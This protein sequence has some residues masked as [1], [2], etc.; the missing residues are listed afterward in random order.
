MRLTTLPLLPLL[1]VLLTS[2]V[3]TSNAT[4][5]ASETAS[6]FAPAAQA[7]AMPAAWHLDTAEHPLVAG[8]P[9]LE[10]AW[11]VSR[12]P[13]GEFDR[14]GL[15]RYRTSGSGSSSVATL[16][17]LP[18]TNMNGIA[19]VKDEAHNLWL[20]LAARGVEVFTIDY[21]THA[22]PIHATAEQ[23]AVLRAW[24]IETF[25]GDIA[26]AAVQVRHET[27][28]DRLYVAGFSRGVSL[29]Y[30]Y[31]CTEPDR[32]AGL[33]HLDGAFKSHAPTSQFDYAAAL[34]KLETG[35]AWASDVAA[36]LGWDRRHQL[37]ATV[38]ANPGAPAT[39]A[40]FPTLGDQLASL[41]QFAWRPGGLANPLGGL[42]KPQTLAT[43]LDGYDRYYPAV[44]DIDGRSIA[45]RPDD[46]RTPVDDAWGKLKTPILHFAST[47][48]GGEFLL[49]GIYTVDKS[50]SS[51]VTLNVLERYGH[52][53]LVVGEQAAR[54]VFQPT[55]D[56][57]KAHAAAR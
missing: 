23:L 24:G 56:W 54:D 10:T 48:M 13:G 5:H 31:T 35:H 57:I 30:A 1:P 2:F 9:V 11:S 22:V 46:P 33:V 8:S 42:S 55:L 14:I 39:D 40:K 32:V 47:G 4:P 16:L 38:S 12:P 29:A 34:G 7:I 51:D 43:L 25:V 15:H 27:G 49:N 45:D 41:L 19:A 50:G 26:A 36:G 21:R 28:R 18:G 44:Q 6:A 53:D 17:Y 20:F 52:L 3:L 37:M